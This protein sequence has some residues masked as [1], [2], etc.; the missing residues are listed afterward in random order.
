MI[1]KL[2]LGFM[3]YLDVFSMTEGTLNIFKLSYV[4]KIL[5]FIIKVN[6]FVVPEMDIGTF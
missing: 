4:K 5:M 6:K 1:F 3:T 2:A